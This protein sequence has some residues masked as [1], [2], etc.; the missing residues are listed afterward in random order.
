[1]ALQ[2][3]RYGVPP[4][5]AELFVELAVYDQQTLVN[6]EQP[7][8]NGRLSEVA[9]DCFRAIPFAESGFG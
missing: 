1:M 3:T 9:N 2:P 4:V 6:V 7:A 5:E 8:E